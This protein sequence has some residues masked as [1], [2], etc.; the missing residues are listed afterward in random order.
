M[1]FGRM[2][3]RPFLTVAGAGFDAQVGLDFHEHGRR[4]GRRGVFTYVWLSVLRTLNYRAESWGLDA[5]AQK[6]EGGAYIVAF[7]NG[8]RY[9]GG[10][11]LVPGAGL[12]DG[13]LDIVV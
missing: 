5:G 10:A 6:L 1:G 9:G 3:E 4:G 11:V 8:R 2:N 12:D 13:L 7:V